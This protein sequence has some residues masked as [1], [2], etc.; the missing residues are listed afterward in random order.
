[1]LCVL[2]RE[3]QLIGD[4]QLQAAV[5]QW[6]AGPERPLSEVFREEG[7]L[8]PQQLERLHSLADRRAAD[9][10]LDPVNSHLRS[11]PPAVRSLLEGNAPPTERSFDTVPSRPPSSTESVAAG[12]LADDDR[13]AVLH[14]HA[15]GGLGVVFQARDEQI[16]RVVALKQIKPQWADDDESRTRFVLE[17]KITGRLEHPGIVPIYA[18]GADETGR[19]YYAM[20]LIRGESMLQVI[21]RFHHTLSSVGLDKNSR[22]VQLRK[23]LTRFI[24]VCNAL[25]YAH[26]HGI[27][28]R[29]VKPANVMVGKFGETLVVD[30]GLAKVVGA[31]EESSPTS[32]LQWTPLDDPDTTSTR[33]GAAVGT[34]A[35]M[36]PEQAAGRLD[37]IGPGA[38]IYSLGAT[39]YQLLTGTTPHPDEPDLGVLLAQIEQG[40]ITPAERRA[41][42]L[43]RPL[44][45]ICRRAMAPLPQDRYP[46][47]RAVADDVDRWLADEP[48]RA[49]AE[50]LPERTFRW[51]RNHRTLVISA[52]AAQLVAAIAVVVGMIGW[53]HFQ[54]RRLQDQ[55]AL[56]SQERQR[57]VV[58]E[59]AADSAWNSAANELE[60]SRFPSALAL[61]EAAAKTLDD[62]PDLA[63]SLRRIGE[64][65]ERIAR[66]VRYERLTRQAEE[67]I[68]FQNDTAARRLLVDALG[69]LGVLEHGD[70][71]A[72]LPVEDLSPEQANALRWDVYRQLILLTANYAKGAFGNLLGASGVAAAK[73]TLAM[74]ERVERF[75]PAAATRWHASCARMR[76]GRGLPARLEALPAPKNGAD[77]YMLGALATIAT[78]NQALAAFF[79]TE[80]DQLVAQ[81]RRHLLLASTLA[82]E[83]Y[84]THFVLGY[85]EMI[86]AGEP[87]QTPPEVSRPYYQNAR[88][89]FAQCIAID[90]DYWLAYAERCNSYRQEIEARRAAGIAEE[91]LDGQTTDQLREMMLRD[92]EKVRQLQQGHLAAQWYVAFA[93]HTANQHEAALEAMFE[94]LKR[95]ARFDVDGDVRILDPELQR[96]LPE[97]IQIANEWLDRQ[98]EN[99]HYLLLRAAAQWRQEAWSEAADDVE[100]VLRSESPPTLAWVVRGAIRLHRRE[101]AAAADDFRAALAVD[102]DQLIALVG[103]A[104]TQEASGAYDA[105]QKLYEQGLALA[106]T[107]YQVAAIQLGRARTWLRQGEDDQAYEA[108]ALARHAE[109]STEVETIRRVAKELGREAFLEKVDHLVE[110]PNLAASDAARPPEYQTLPLL[111]GSFELGLGV[112]WNNL[113][114]G[115]MSWQNVDGCQAVAETVYRSDRGG[116]V[117]FIDNQQSAP[118]G[119]GQTSQTI[120][121][122][123]ERTYRLSAWVRGA[124]LA[125]GALRIVVGDV[126]AP[127]VV[128][129]APGTYGWR[130]VS[131]RFSAADVGSPGPEGLVPATVRIVMAGA[132]K[133]WLD[134]IT[135]QR[136]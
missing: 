127:P 108:V 55:V 89:A 48:V 122:D 68:A 51:M 32:H 129:S 86:A 27:I 99:L 62:E 7:L 114:S 15:Q 125:P 30:W 91:L 135:I 112:H 39:L 96:A 4:D 54:S 101:H 94:A 93:L 136:E 18:L 9:T 24:D 8:D 100:T 14:L 80:P 76:L 25:E 71:W 104:Q 118:R 38:D 82:P 126:A 3:E 26:S 34:P 42:W 92:L 121:A 36:S 13:F 12:K 69:S 130:Q 72:H 111:D 46:T 60:A 84:W 37:E 116:N 28:H 70:W 85:I 61:L 49:Y 17:A 43:P 63:D 134:E 1:M 74:A 105:A 119:Y 16:D 64:R 102:P 106:D 52:A 11:L 56:E 57:K 31:D 123:P 53:N 103:L 77:A 124:D 97:V 87:A 110:E 113:E 59:A 58:L 78:Q 120:P 79:T 23:L 6:V 35:Y 95:N 2:V 50:R 10:C 109:P 44:A 73:N 22:N 47:A 75:R 88:R 5:Q 81:A 40:R 115:A 98:P 132:G 29:D 83:Y 65:R 45:A 131:G 67:L 19:P 133:V 33:M 41:A 90:P 66:L 20:R 128:E 21:D 117:L 107:S